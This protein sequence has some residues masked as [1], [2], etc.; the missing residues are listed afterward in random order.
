MKSL[1]RSSP[2]EPSKPLFSYYSGQTLKW[3]SHSTFSDNLKLLLLE[4]GYD[5]KRYTCHSFR[6]GGASFGFELGMSITDIKQR[7]DWASNAVQDYIFIT[8]AQIDST[9]KRLIDGASRRADTH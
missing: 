7:G 2:Y 3:W 5:A 4:A 1:L 8:Q 6:R 9:A